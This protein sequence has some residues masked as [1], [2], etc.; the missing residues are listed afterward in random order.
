VSSRPPSGIKNQLLLNKLV[1]AV[2]TTRIFKWLEGST[3]ASDHECKNVE[4]EAGGDMA[5][6][7]MIEDEMSPRRS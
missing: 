4:Q 7:E 6:W 3:G 5:M 2:Q 1:Q